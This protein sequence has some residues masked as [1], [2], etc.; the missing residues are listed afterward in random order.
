MDKTENNFAG[1]KTC[2]FTGHR[3]GAFPWTGR[4]DPRFLKFMEALEKEIDIAIEQG[5]THFICGNA[6]G[7]DT[8]AAELVIKKKQSNPGLTLEIAVPF[9]GHND[10]NA[11]VTAVQ[12]ASDLVHVVS[13][14]TNMAAAY[15]ERNRYMVDSSDTLIAVYDYRSNQKGGTLNTLNYAKKQ[16]KTVSQICWMDFLE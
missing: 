2:C 7:V 8:W 9:T 1:K 16:K 13:S 11:E 6:L 15:H 12:A 4:E 14:A 10:C 5:V 3:P